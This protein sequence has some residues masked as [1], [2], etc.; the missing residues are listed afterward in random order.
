LDYKNCKG[1]KSATICKAAKVFKKTQ[2]CIY[3]VDSAY[4]AK[5]NS[6]TICKASEVSKQNPAETAHC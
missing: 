2:N 3:T 4:T 1:Q 5:N 6:D